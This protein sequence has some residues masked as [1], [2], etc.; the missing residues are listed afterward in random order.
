MSHLENQSHIGRLE[1]IEVPNNSCNS[2][3][4]PGLEW[5]RILQETFS[6]T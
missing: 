5:L 3:Y 6:H 2:G 4:L 1:E